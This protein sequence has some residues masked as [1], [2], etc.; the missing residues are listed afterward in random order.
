MKLFDW[1]TKAA[2]SVTISNISTESSTEKVYAYHS[3]YDTLE[4]VNR[5]VNMIVDDA[6]SFSY[7]HNEYKKPRIAKILNLLNFRPNP[8]QDAYTFKRNIVLDLVLDGNIFIYYDG[9]YVWQLPAT[10][11]S[12][13]RDDTQVP[14]GYKVTSDER[15]YLPEEVIHIRDNGYSLMRGSS[16]LKSCLNSMKMLTEM[17]SFQANFFNNGAVP[18]LV[19]ST[20][21]TLSD[22]IKER[23]AQQ[24]RAKFNPKTGGRN[25]V[26]LDGGMKIDS[27]SNVNFKELDF[28]TGV[29]SIEGTICKAM[30]IPPILLDGGNNANIKPNQRLY[31]SETIQ[32]IAKKLAAG[33]GR[34][35]GLEIFEDITTILGMQPDLQEQASFY[36]TLVNGGILKPNEAREGLGFEKD[37][38][39]ASDKLRIPQNITGSASNPSL[40]G[41][42]KEPTN[43]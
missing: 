24:W 26:I 32:P 42:P 18:G 11:V 30:G 2:P 37:E 16:R 39:P 3:Y 1:F 17:K 25:P 10:E 21:A 36:Q 23:M 27:I 29:T 31:Y 38:D 15:P 35:F 13:I 14:I 33:F 34:F 9:V 43:G 5:V 8:D 19:L 28:Q 40:G 6:A 41:R 4:I 22:K 12:I 20:E 7:T